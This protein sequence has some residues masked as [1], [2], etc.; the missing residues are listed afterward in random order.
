ML[1]DGK[2][3]ADEIKEY[4]K[5]QVA[6]ENVNL[7]MAFVCVGENSAINKFVQL[8]QKFGNETGIKTIL[9]KFSADI[10]E[11]DLKNKITDIANNG[12]VDGIVVQL[13][14]PKHINTDKVLNIIPVSKD[15]DVLSEESFDLF[16][17]NKLRIFPPVVGA[18]KEIFERH[19]VNLKGKKIVVIGKGRLVGAPVSAW[20]FNSGFLPVVLDEYDDIEDAVK[21]ADV[22]I[23]GAGSPN[24][25]KP[26]MLKNGII[27]IDAGTSPAK[28]PRPVYAYA[29]RRDMLRNHGAGDLNGQLVGDIDKSCDEKAELF[30]SV[31]GGIGPITIAVL[32]RNILLLNCLNIK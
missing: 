6:R 28:L 19:N 8:K 18:I 13:P 32:F 12:S 11:S 9:N 20:L 14:L 30:S 22:I 17:K 24:I 1:V 23:S 10:L 5:E 21:N 7:R 4:L 31:P 2:K 3:I 15:P 26:E 27:L 29:N 16:K 25:I